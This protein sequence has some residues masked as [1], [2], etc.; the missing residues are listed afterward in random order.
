MPN[1]ATQQFPTRRSATG[2]RMHSNMCMDD[3]L[4]EFARHTYTPMSEITVYPGTPPTDIQV[5]IQKASKVQE[6]KTVFL[7][8]Y[9]EDQKIEAREMSLKVNNKR[10]PSGNFF[11]TSNPSI[12]QDPKDNM[13]TP[14]DSVTQGAL[15]TM[16]HTL[17]SSTTGSTGQK[18]SSTK[19]LDTSMKTGFVTGAN[20]EVNQT[21]LLP[22]QTGTR[23]MQTARAVCATRTPNGAFAQR[24]LAMYG[25]S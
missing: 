19:E 4:K 12:Y 1:T 10:T 20:H 16:G 23:D 21:W 15:Q 18:R 17:A 9:L 11:G 6:A 5:T 22:H 7:P 14:Q 3:M 24:S 8:K 13:H 25:R 2:T